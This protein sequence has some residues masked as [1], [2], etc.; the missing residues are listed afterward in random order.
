MATCQPAFDLARVGVDTLATGLEVPWDVAFLPDGRALITERP[1]RIRVWSPTEG[2]LERPFWTFDRVGDQEVGLMGIAAHTR[3]DGRV[4]V[5]TAVTL[6]HTGG[7][8]LQAFLKGLGR[9]IART[10]TA[11]GGQPRSLH[12]LRFGVEPGVDVGQAPDSLVRLVPV[13][14]L[15]GGGAIDIGPD[16]LIYVTN[17][18]GAEPPRAFDTTTIAGK[19]LRYH[20]DGRPAPLDPDAQVPWVVRG[21][22]NSQGIG[23]HPMTEQLVVLEHG[24][25]GMLQEDGQV[26]NDELNVV[27]LGDDLGWPV[28]AGA[29]RG[30]DLLSPAVEW[31]FGIAPA[32]LAI[33]G[34]DDVAW[35][36][37]ALVTG[38]KDG[39]LRRVHFDPSDPS[40]FACQEPILDRGYGRLRMV[41]V[42]PDGSLWVGTSNR[43]GRGGPRA[44]DD[45]LLRVYTREA[46]APPTGP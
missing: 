20:L 14:H 29:S 37:S 4:E 35:G 10:F 6:D 15:H 36:P 46:V 41:A 11:E 39:R 21:L 2:I 45:L 43:D 8:P 30:G 16:G 40:S 33:A 19:V 26:G 5:Y 12:I 24:P 28:V 34:I 1:G 32:G 38:L 22:R 44:G 23:W 7:P 9:R 25:T 31:T 3:A 27:S 42:A 18:D 17:G 13:G